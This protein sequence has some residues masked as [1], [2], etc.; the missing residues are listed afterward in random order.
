MV[1]FKRTFSILGRPLPPVDKRPVNASRYTEIS[2][3]YFR[4]LKIPSKKGRDL[5]EA[6]RAGAPW[7]AVVNET[8]VRRYFP[9][10]DPIGQH[11]TSFSVSSISM[12]PSP[13]KLWALSAISTGIPWP[14]PSPSPSYTL[15]ISNSRQTSAVA[16]VETT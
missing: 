16:S 13:G 8:F 11:N 9:N 6:D 1:V 15:R 12:K 10:E 14:K 5:T 2:P 4:T 3:A 7:A